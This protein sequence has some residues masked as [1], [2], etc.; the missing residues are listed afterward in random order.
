MP[1]TAAPA[2]A[3]ISGPDV[4]GLVGVIELI[5]LVWVQIVA[6]PIQTHDVGI[7]FGVDGDYGVYYTK[8]S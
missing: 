1:G 7:V 5:R 3:G 6:G 2:A 8:D 4:P